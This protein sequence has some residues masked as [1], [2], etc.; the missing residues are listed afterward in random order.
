MDHRYAGTKK[1]REPHPDVGC[2]W[3]LYDYGLDAVKLWPRD[4]VHPYPGGDPPPPP[5]ETHQ[6]HVSS[7]TW[8][9]S[10]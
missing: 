6:K 2:W 5:P 10:P 4:H 1:K 7:I 8:L 9:N 3:S